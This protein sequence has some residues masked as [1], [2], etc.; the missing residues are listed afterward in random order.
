MKIAFIDSGVGG[1]IFAIDC[2]N[3]VMKKFDVKRNFEVIHIGDTANI[4]YGLKKPDTLYKLSNQLIQKAISLGAD[5]IF[6]ACNT[7][8]TIVDDKMINY[9]KSLGIQLFTLVDKSSIAIYQEYQKT[10]GNIAIFGTVQTI[11]S[12]KYYNQIYKIHQEFGHNEKLNV[13]PYAPDNWVKMIEDGSDIEHIAK[14]VFQTLDDF[15]RF[16]DTD[17]DDIS[18]IGL[19]CTHYSYL[20]NEIVNYFK[21]YSSFS[22]DVHIMSQGELFADDVVNLIKY[23]KQS[24][25]SFD[26]IKINSYITGN[27]ILQIRKVISSLY[28][29]IEIMFN[30]ID[31]C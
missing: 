30:K 6:V 12:G 25:D 19:F 14:S 17:F 18:C 23:S 11:F 31:I 7:I 10:K 27:N 21:K 4:P 9:Y 20:K 2:L 24:N 8:S 15:R 16:A 5:A 26:A 1:L 28:S 29:N 3:E 22:G 13:I